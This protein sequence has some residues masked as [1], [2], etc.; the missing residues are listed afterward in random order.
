MQIVATV[1]EK[2]VAAM[3]EKP[4]ADRIII[5]AAEAYGR[6]LHYCLE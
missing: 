2:P 1:T 3:T 6:S 5:I 4:I